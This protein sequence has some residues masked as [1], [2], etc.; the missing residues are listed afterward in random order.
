VRFLRQR[1]RNG[2]D[3]A[4]PYVFGSGPGVYQATPPS[5]APPQVPWMA[6]MQPLALPVN[7][8]YRAPRPPSLGSARWARDYDEVKRLGSATSTERTP[9]QTAIGL[10]YTEHT[11]FQYARNFRDLAAS[12]ALPLADNARLFAQ[13]YVASA[14]ALI[15]CWDSKFAHEFWRPVTAIR[16]GDTDGNP[17]TAPDAAWT[18]LATTPGHPEYPSAHSCFTSAWT[19]SVEHFFGT[20]DIP[21]TLTSTVPGSGNTRSFSSTEAVVAE[22]VEARIFGGMH[23]RFSCEEGTR[24]GKRVADFVDRHFFR[25]SGR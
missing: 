9:E 13:I 16:A 4:V 12:R 17:A 10:F 20:E 8:R 22:L 21:I 15:A 5:F 14:D 11:G 2:R 3:A 18:P 1:S 6:A 23:Y 19:E 7:W 24:I 25:P